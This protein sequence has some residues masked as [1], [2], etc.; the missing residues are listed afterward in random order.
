MF[1][2][3]SPTPKDIEQAASENLGVNE[4]VNDVIDKNNDIIN[5]FVHFN[6][7]A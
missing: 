2:S 1:E 6:D 5:D 4:V 3:E 7:K